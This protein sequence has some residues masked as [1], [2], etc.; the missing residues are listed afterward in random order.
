VSGLENADD[1]EYLIYAG[2]QIPHLRRK[3]CAKGSRGTEGNETKDK[4]LQ[5]RG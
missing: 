5:E 1:F 2:D 3:P 4:N